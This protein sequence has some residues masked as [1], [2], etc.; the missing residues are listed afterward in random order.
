MI[1]RVTTET[2]TD[3]PATTPPDQA[4]ALLRDQQVILVRD[5]I[6][7]DVVGRFGRTFAGKYDDYMRRHSAITDPGRRQRF[8]SEQFPALQI[9]AGLDR[10][11]VVRSIARSPAMEIMRSYFG[12]E[13]IISLWD[14]T[15]YAA[16]RGPCAPGTSLPFHQ[17]GTQFGSLGVRG[18]ILL[19]PEVAGDQAAGIQFL[20]R[21]LD[22]RQ[23]LPIS[24]DAAFSVDTDPGALAP[25]LAKHR[26]WVPIVRLGDVVLFSGDVLHATYAA[27]G[28]TQDRWALQATFHA[29]TPENLGHFTTNYSLIDRHGTL[30]PTH[31]TI[32]RWWSGRPGPIAADAVPGPDFEFVPLI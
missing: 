5:A 16:R 10:D 29:G 15:I 20:P 18:W 12:T 17:D 31:D 9:E 26:P 21:A 7:R 6:D 2:C 3:L 24:P 1:R 14:L 8:M 13:Q 30:F 32:E 28:T 19:H 4:A 27:E 25:V 11:A 23:Y 22:D